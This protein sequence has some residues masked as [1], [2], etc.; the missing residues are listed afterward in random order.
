MLGYKSR[1]IFCYAVLATTLQILPEGSVKDEATF[2]LLL[3]G[4]AVLAG[5]AIYL[6]IKRRKEED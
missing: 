1:K 6:R 3:S 5:A 2:F 4:L